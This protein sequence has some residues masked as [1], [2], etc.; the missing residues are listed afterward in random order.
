MNF[1]LI[2]TELNIFI[3]NFSVEKF[4]EDNKNSLEL[5]QYYFLK[6]NIKAN[7]YLLKSLLNPSAIQKL[8]AYMYS[9]YKDKRSLF[10]AREKDLNALIVYHNLLGVLP[11]TLEDLNCVV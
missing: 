7:T 9:I 1:N 11:I 10:I 2:Y 4:N 6:N 8:P 5:I 3:P